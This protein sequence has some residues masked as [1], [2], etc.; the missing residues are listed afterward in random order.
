[1]VGAGRP[2]WSFCGELA[3]A[4]DADAGD[5][6]GNDVHH[7]AGDQRRQAAGHVEPDPSDRHEPVGDPGARPQLG[8]HLRLQLGL[9]GGPQPAD[10]LL[11]AGPDRRVERLQRLRQRRG[12]HPQVLGGHP[13]E[14]QGELLD[15]RGAAGPDGL[16]DRAHHLDR[17]LH[18]ELRTR[19]DGAVV[20][21]R[22]RATEVDPA[23]QG[24]GHGHDSRSSEDVHVRRSRA[25][26]AAASGEARL[27]ASR[28]L[29]VRQS[30]GW[31][32]AASGE[33]RL[34]ASR[35]TS[36]SGRAGGGRPQR[37]AK[38]ACARADTPPRPAE[39]GVDGRADTPSGPDPGGA[40]KRDRT[41]TLRT[42]A[43]RSRCSRS[44][45]CCSPA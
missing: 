31:T 28:H 35:H 13:V 32:A 36:T 2:P 42:W 4:I 45:P 14:A 43:T 16:A 3:R 37:A 27:R 30:R 40:K 15:R 18:V 8:D 20:L 39:P 33:A 25:W 5:L 26:T 41:T 29:H 38:R 7:H 11:E 17:R 22:G 1:M 34:R 21:G 9:A 10:R 6:C 12:R 44:T 19:Y 24:M 23:D